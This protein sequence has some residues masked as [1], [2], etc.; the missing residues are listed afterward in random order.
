MR[1]DQP[2]A[3]VNITNKMESEGTKITKLMSA[4]DWGQW[5]FQVSVL[6]RDKDA[7][8]ILNGDLEKPILVT[9]PTVAEHQQMSS[10]LK[11]DN[12]A[13]KIIA[14]GVVDS[15]LVHIM[16]CN[17]A[18]DM[19]LALHNL[20]EQ[21]SE[22]SIHMLQQQWY[23]LNKAPKDSMA[24]HIA[25]LKDL[26]HR[27]EALGEPI[28]DSMIMT[29]ILMTLPPAY[30]HFVTAW[31]SSPR[32]E[33][34]L[35]NLVERLLAEEI[36]F[37]SQE[38]GL[39]EALGMMKVSSSKKTG[40]RKR[41]RS[42]KSSKETD[43]PN[44]VD[45]DVCFNCLKPGHWAHG[46]RAEKKEASSRD[47][48]PKGQAMIAETALCVSKSQS[49]NEIWYVDSGATHH[50]TNQEKWFL[51]LK[52]FDNP[53]PVIVGK[54]GESVEALGQGEINILAYDGSQWAEKHLYQVL[55]VPNLRYNL[56]SAGSAL[57]KGLTQISTAK[58]CRFKENGTTVAVG[59]R[60]HKL[61]EMQFQ[62]LAP[63][64]KD[65]D[66]IE[67]N[68]A[69]KNSS[70]KSWHERLAHQNSFYVKQYLKARQIKVVD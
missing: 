40:N 33:R 31:E 25:K 37:L 14:T 16:N 10:W 69:Q 52:Y 7:F 26:A 57:D 8:K 9:E 35:P 5:K 56:F 63:E 27:L 12:T 65:I 45:E 43:A 59:V 30:N 1:L 36:R 55:F 38:K 6:L 48:K 46:C 64:A 15:L 28:V 68:L 18:K 21:K 11:A 61:C 3:K 51:N 39:S 67:A 2:R 34:K 47:K 42:Q 24:I 62:V 19:C 44:K 41:K 54:K 50:M 58:G 66:E 4:E 60:N 32:S 53:Q 49:R 20:F 22:T 23:Q 13:Q 70:L 29:K 17:N